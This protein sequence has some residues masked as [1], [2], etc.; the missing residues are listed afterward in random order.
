M[1]AAA[2]ATVA[3]P[4]A[5]HAAEEADCQ[6]TAVHAL[7]KGD[8]TIP[9]SLDFLADQLKDD[10]FAAYKSF[11]LIERKALKL[12]RDTA[13]EARFSTGNRIGLT[14]LGNEGSRLKLHADIRSRNGET[15]LLAADYSIANGGVLL[16]RAGEL[17]HDGETGKLFFAIQCSGKV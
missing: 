11:K 6:L 1:P 7:K 17:E 16:V 10:E 5:A 13:S 4:T 9:K 15:K 8:G 3:V 2:L 14:L 12:K